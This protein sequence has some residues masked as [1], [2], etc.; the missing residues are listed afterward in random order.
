MAPIRFGTWWLAAAAAA[1]GCGTD[2]AVAQPSEAGGITVEAVG[3]VRA[4]PDRM[5]FA[6]RLD[7]AAELAGDALVKHREYKRR[8]LEALAEMQLE[9]LQI[10]IFGASLRQT[11]LS[12]GNPDPFEEGAPAAVS[13]V[14][15]LSN[16]IRIS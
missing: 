12:E 14:T 4:P 8:A 10:E 1:I 13:P 2:F 5:E 6:T 3:E 7:G 11:G 16:R 15:T 9:D